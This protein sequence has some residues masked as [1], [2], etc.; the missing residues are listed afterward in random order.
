MELSDYLQIL[1]AYWRSI[2]AVTL[3]ALVAAA[4]LSV[5]TR[6]T[7]TA[8]STL[9]FS[10]KNA[11]T[12]GELNAGST[13]VEGQVQSFAKVAVSPMVLQPV[14]DKLGL[15]TT[16]DKLAGRV[17]TTVPTNTA[18][19]DIAV[20]DG[21]AT[22]AAHIAAAI[23]DGL[24]AAVPRLAP[25][26]ADGVEPVLATIIRPAT[27]PTSPTS[28]KVLQNL[29]LGLLLGLLLGVGQA[30]ARSVLDQRVK[31]ERDLE[32][33]TDLPVLGSIIA[34]E[35]DDDSPA[36]LIDGN[37]R[38]LRAEAYRR[39]RT[40]LQFLGLSE[41]EKV[42]AV[43]S[44]LP[45]EGKSI[46]AIN[47][48]TTLAAAGERVLLIDADLRKP[49]LSSKLRVEGAVGLTTVLI[50][51]ATLADVIQPYGSTPLSILASGPVPPNPAE[52][53]GF[54]TMQRILA[55]ASRSYDAVI[56]DTPPLLPV[57]DA[58]VVSQIV[59]GTL[60]VVG[61]GEVRKPQLGSALDSLEQVEA[62]VL[63]VVMNKVR[64]DSTGQ[65]SYH[66]SYQPTKRTKGAEGE[67]AGRAA[68]ATQDAYSR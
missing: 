1:R 48:A 53:L 36:L 68:R 10:I 14:I 49:T 7:Y 15:D 34:T 57:T 44:S 27:S 50:G 6:P 65:Y 25:P 23:S 16:P 37:P 40:N 5:L 9:F 59:N 8:S 43:T 4:A 12:V 19:M 35:D 56:I 32:T 30:I 2:V 46:T 38:S 62:R 60:V 63:G 47:I 20:E 28:P 67:A 18:T 29:A 66:Y 31:S 33:V 58:A 11:S 61:S 52:L 13:Y 64:S 41:G 55:E 17:K 22:E 26:G 24:I 42:I 54:V 45:G 3:A 51:D 21:S 39:L